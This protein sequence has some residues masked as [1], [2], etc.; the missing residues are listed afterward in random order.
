MTAPLSLRFAARDLRGGLKGFRIFLACLTLGVAAIAGVGSLSSAIRAG[1]ETN[2][3]SLLGAD[4]EIRVA[5]NPAEPEQVGWME[6]RSEAVSLI[7]QL[8]AMAKAGGADGEQTL[9]ELKAVNHAGASAYPLYGEI[10]LDPPLPLADALGERDGVHG[11]VAEATL[12]ARIGI[13]IG[14]ELTLAGKRLQLRA[15]ILNEP[16]RISGTFALGPRLMISNAGLDATGLV[17]RGSLVRHKYRVR[18]GPDDDIKVW[19]KDLSEA[20]PEAAWRVFDVDK[21]QP[22][23]KRFVDRL[24]L[25]LT[26]V[27]LTALVIGGVGVGNAVQAYLGGKT[28]TIATLKCL[29]ADGGL[30]FRTYLIEIGGLAA[31]GIIIGLA[32]G[33]A[34][35]MAALS[36]LEGELPLTANL[37]VYPEPLFRAAAFG[38]LTALAFALWPLARARRVP[39]AGLFRDMV[40]KAAQLP[41][42]RD[43]LVIAMATVGLI[44]LALTSGENVMIARWFVVSAAGA[45]F[46]FWLLGR[47]IIWTLR[48]L[49][50]AR[51]PGL[52]LAMANL[53]RPGAPTAGI[54]ISLG[55]GL[56]VLVTIALIEGNLDRQ[57]QS[58]I[59]ER[60]PSFFF[61]DIQSDQTEAFDRAV[62]GIEGS[63]LIQRLPT[64]RGRVATINGEK[65][66]GIPVEQDG[67]WFAHNEIGFTYLSEMPADT[68]LS[69]GDWW[70]EDY[71]GEP[72]I[73][74]GA[75][76]A[77]HF[78][79]N[80][81]DTITFNILGRRI[82]TRIANFR[83][84]D[85]TQMRL[86]FAVIF[87]PGALEGAP[88]VHGAAASAPPERE[89][90]LRDAVT[91]ALPNVSA[92][93]VG[94][95][96]ATVTGMFERIA[97]AIRAS[98]GVTLIAGILVLAGALAAGYSRRVYDAV[99]LKV[100][101]ATRGDIARAYMIEYA[102]LGIATAMLA[103]LVG[104]VAS[105]AVVT[106]FMS[107]EWI[108]LPVAMTL[109]AGGGIVVTVLLGFIGTWRALG[110]KAATV[111]RQV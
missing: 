38:A 103:A 62:A 95:V 4:V 51:R 99:V 63:E 82:K 91:K 2:A 105:W 22:S 1:I 43:L 101:G 67:A 77:E 12:L 31:L 20:F 78:K 44:V 98:A 89:S 26:L 36:V 71:R 21:A 10:S 46:T 47:I 15:V 96:L 74:L 34:L 58:R 56:T 11:A 72:A 97:A 90:A 18:L 79:L 28:E 33:A 23:V 9:V 83:V 88:Q 61:I 6:S 60:A 50:R 54:V 104:T 107:G 19:S 37:D 65:V 94:D 70:P 81:G 17:Q 68:V 84:I 5:S 7:R 102:L 87:A 93:R 66:D 14:D 106:G 80:V 76:I 30:I 53:T 41:P 59:P 108:F 49:P 85:W 69:A 8:R 86:N 25:F 110:Q 3:R 42:L 55:A 73:S 52:R 48:A 109:T 75:H 32:L 100:L 111:L 92:V 13:Q 29:G 39:A 27:G 35:P 24:G 64:L 57:V 16:D 45:M 40:S